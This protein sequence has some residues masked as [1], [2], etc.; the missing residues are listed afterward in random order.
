MAQFLK[1]FVHQ[2]IVTTTQRVKTIRTDLNV[3]VI[4][5]TLETVK[6]VPQFQLLM[7]AKLVIFA[8]ILYSFYPYNLYNCLYFIHIIPG[9]NN[10]AQNTVCIDEQYGYRCECQDGHV[11]DEDSNAEGSPYQIEYDFKS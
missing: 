1:I 3:H 5:D 10:C 9:D 8:N 2:Q 11:E 4:Q 6:R 7:N